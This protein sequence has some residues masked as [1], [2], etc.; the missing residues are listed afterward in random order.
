MSLV[1]SLYAGALLLLGVFTLL[2]VLTVGLHNP[3]LL[4]QGLSL[5]VFESLAMWSNVLRG[6]A[7]APGRSLQTGR[8]VSESDR[9]RRQPSDSIFFWRHIASHTHCVVLI[10]RHLI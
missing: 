3:Q 7:S 8:L 2:A 9:P 10:T 6:L 5:D 4:Y 1:E